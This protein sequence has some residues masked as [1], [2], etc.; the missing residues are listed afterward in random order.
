MSKFVPIE[1]SEDGHVR[2][3]AK[4]G[5]CEGSGLWRVPHRRASQPG[6]AE[7]CT[8]CGGRGWV[9]AYV[10]QFADSGESTASW[11]FCLGRG[12]AHYMTALRS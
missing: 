10:R 9:V 4:C 1:V 2:I 5:T 3:V 11:V 6:L 7:Q 8:S 12:F